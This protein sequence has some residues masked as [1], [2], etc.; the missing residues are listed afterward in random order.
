MS[1]WMACG[2][3]AYVSE[4]DWLLTRLRPGR[5]NQPP[6]QEVDQYYRCQEPDQVCTLLGPCPKG[7]ISLQKL[8]L[9]ERY[10]NHCYSRAANIAYDLR[11]NLQLH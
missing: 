4:K 7:L 10:S 6:H 3:E 11:I 5:G 8:F 1:S 9:P 2:P